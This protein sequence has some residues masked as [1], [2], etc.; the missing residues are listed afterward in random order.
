[1]FSLYTVVSSSESVLLFALAFFSSY[2]IY[3]YVFYL[4]SHLVS[5]LAFLTLIESGR[6]ILPGLN[7]PQKEKALAL[8]LAALAGL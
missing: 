8:L 2:A 1:M 7:L 5:L 6:R 4:T 3:Y